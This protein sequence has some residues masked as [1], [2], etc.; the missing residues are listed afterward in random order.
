M[1]GFERYL[2]EKGFEETSVGVYATQV[3]YFLNWLENEQ[4][5]SENVCYND[6][7]NYVRHLKDREIK[8]DT[9]SKYMGYLKHYFNFLVSKGEILSNVI[10]HVD[11]HGVRKT[12]LYRVFTQEELDTI[13]QEFPNGKQL[14]EGM[15][16][17]AE[18]RDKVILSFFIYQGITTTDLRKL[19]EQSV[20]LE[21]GMLHIPGSKRINARTLELN[22]RQVLDIQRYL[23]VARMN[24]L[25]E[26][27][28]KTDQL[29]IGYY[30][31]KNEYHNIIAT[32]L[33]KLRA[34]FEEVESL[35]H[36][37][38]SVI[39]NWLSDNNLRQVQYMAG[40]R[41]VSSTEKFLR[42]D[43]ETLLNEF[44]KYAP[45]I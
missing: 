38:A 17:D 21:T 9:I 5:C 39:T 43:T 7:M 37:R 3:A 4:L 22:P 32:L 35:K 15:L 24:I 40:H 6:M 42:N 20:S 14:F 29:I 33:R 31:G 11:I 28:E 1:E 16:T 26:R 18:Q 34:L 12:G 44:E 13:Y 2:L 23:Q 41:F 30:G 8:Q 25:K 45:R 36:L 27:P 10:Q 19:T